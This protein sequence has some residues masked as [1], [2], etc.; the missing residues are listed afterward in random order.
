M[1]TS[2][3]I[4]CGA[5]K[6]GALTPCS[7]C[8]FVPELNEDKAKAMILTDH[9]LPK[10]ELEKISK[11]LQAGQPVTYPED[12]IKGYIKTFDRLPFCSYVKFLSIE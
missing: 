11:R 4:Q 9:F 2:V 6:F 5:M 12:M 7:S 3:C 8:Q 10:E 1:T